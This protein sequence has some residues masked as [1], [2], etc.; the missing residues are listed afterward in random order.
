[1]EAFL[2]PQPGDL[3]HFRPA[4]LYYYAY[5]HGLEIE[6]GLEAAIESA[7][8]RVNQ[9]KTQTRPQSY[10]R[11][12]AIVSAIVAL[13]GNTLDVEGLFSASTNLAAFEKELRWVKA[14]AALK[15]ARRS[16][17]ARRYGEGLTR[18]EAIGHEIQS[19]V[20]Q[21]PGCG[22]SPSIVIGEIVQNF[23][24][25][26]SQLVLNLRQNDSMDPE[27]LN[28]YRMLDS[29]HE[30]MMKSLRPIDCPALT[31]RILRA[32]AT[33]HQLKAEALPLEPIADS[34]LRSAS[35]ALDLADHLEGRQ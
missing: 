23:V 5:L 10:N 31:A 35:R 20:S 4:K 6:Q 28:I 18:L 13:E 1:V 17:E 34:H 30:L 26:G 29:T 21:S 24:S 19:L 15:D 8:Q 14:L 7:T 25:M 3:D 16:I 12:D 33:F 27:S 2:N 22:E 9:L 11:S 32:S